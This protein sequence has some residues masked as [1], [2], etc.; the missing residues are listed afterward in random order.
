MLDLS[1]ETLSRNIEWAMHRFA[2]FDFTTIRGDI[3]SG[4]HDRFL[5]AKQRKAQGE[6]YTPPS[7]A[8][9]MLDRLDLAPE[10]RVLDP[11]CGSGTFLI[12]RY[13]QVVG[14]DAERG[15][16]TYDNA[17]QAIVR[18]AGND[19]NPFSAV[20]TRIQLLWHLL[21]FGEEVKSHGL[22][23]IRVSERANSLVPT[24]LAR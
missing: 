6:F 12:E 7:I 3:L 24:D 20:L 2:R 16:A 15:I 14:E 11:C 10:D 18:I 5:D 19:L 21:S 23:A 9:Y 13:Q 22:P 1:D 8:R 4:I 17:R